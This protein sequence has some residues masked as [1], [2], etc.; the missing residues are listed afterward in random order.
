VVRSITPYT[1]CPEYTLYKKLH[2]SNQS[3]SPRDVLEALHLPTLSNRT[4]LHLKKG[5][6][7][8]QSPP[9]A[10]TLGDSLLGLHVKPPTP[11]SPQG[12][13]PPSPPTTPTT[14]TTLHLRAGDHTL[15]TTVANATPHLFITP[16]TPHFVLHTTKAAENPDGLTI[17]T[18]AVPLY[19]LH[20]TPLT[21]E[22]SDDA[23]VDFYTVYY[24]QPLLSA[25]KNK[26]GKLQLQ[27]HAWL[28]DP[29]A[30]PNEV[31][32]FPDLPF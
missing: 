15:L 1:E 22:L 25:T 17:L 18:E 19:A 30:P 5:T 20:N 29:T 3:P 13:S 28:Y 12:D 23:E 26:K 31:A 24:P 16:T 14:P 10:Q 4:T 7:S 6:T 2:P 27:G 32:F 9:L 8:L 21:L 11:T